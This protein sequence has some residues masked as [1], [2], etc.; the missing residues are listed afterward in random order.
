MLNF[1]LSSSPL[2]TLDI[3]TH[4][5]LSFVSSGSLLDSGLTRLLQFVHLRQLLPLRFYSITPRKSVKV[6]FSEQSTELEQFLVCFVL[7]F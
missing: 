2:S 4:M 6:V 3:L 5:I 7:F 1:L